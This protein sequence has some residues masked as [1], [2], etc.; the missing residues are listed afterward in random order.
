M[1][2][3]ICHFVVYS[4]NH[5]PFDACYTYHLRMSYFQFLLHISFHEKLS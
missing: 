4:W 2:I 3:E 5:Y 1:F